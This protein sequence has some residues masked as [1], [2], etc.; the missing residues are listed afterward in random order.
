MPIATSLDDTETF[1]LKTAPPD[2][3]VTL[4]RMSWGDKLKRQ[5]LVSKMKIQTRRGSKDLQGELDMMAEQTALLEFA[6]CIVD[7]NLT[8][9]TGRKLDFANPDDVKAINGNIGEEISVYIARMNN[10]EEEDE[11]N[12]E[13]NS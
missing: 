13:G 11:A 2:G 12:P 7:H 6:R 4:R 3:Y 9:S 1:Q 10:F 5:A 8:D